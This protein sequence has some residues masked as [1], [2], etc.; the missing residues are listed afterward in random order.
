MVHIFRELSKTIM[1]IFVWGL[2]IY[3]AATSGEMRYLWMLPFSMFAHVG[4]FSHYERIETQNPTE[5][6]ETQETDE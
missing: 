1:F 5:N 2:P 6:E 4:I 3:M